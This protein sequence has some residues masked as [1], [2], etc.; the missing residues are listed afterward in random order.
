M[1][2]NQLHAG[3]T[4]CANHPDPREPNILL[5]KD[6]SGPFVIILGSSVSAVDNLDTLRLVA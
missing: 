1:R 2:C 3:R 5:I 6:P 4:T